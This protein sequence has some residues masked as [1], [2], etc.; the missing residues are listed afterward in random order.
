MKNQD[1]PTRLTDAF[2]IMFPEA[3]SIATEECSRPLEEL[4]EN[5]RNAVASDDLIEVIKIVGTGKAKHPVRDAIRLHAG[6][7]QQQRTI[8]QTSSC[9]FLKTPLRFFNG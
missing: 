9:T 7:P 4:A 3:F 2:R 5:L 6:Y 1:L 8:S